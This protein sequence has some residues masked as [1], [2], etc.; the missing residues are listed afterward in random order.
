MFDNF[1]EKEESNHFEAKFFTRSDDD[2]NKITMAIVNG[3]IQ[4]QADGPIVH[5]S[6]DIFIR[7]RAPHFAPAVLE[8]EEKNFDII[9]LAFFANL[10]VNDSPYDYED[11]RDAGKSWVL[12]ERVAQAL[13]FENLEKP[14]VKY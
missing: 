10:D 5:E 3:V 9:A 2:G 1:D 4:I 13:G 6:A 14:F 7:Y 8:G 12:W 11:S